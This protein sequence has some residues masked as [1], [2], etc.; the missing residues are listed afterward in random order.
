[1]KERDILFA[2]EHVSEKHISDAAPTGRLARRVIVKWAAV[3]ACLLLCVG[4]VLG[5]MAARDPTP[6]GDGITIPQTQ[7]N[8]KTP[9]DGAY[10]MPGL[11]I[12]GGRVYRHVQNVDN[13]RLCGRYVATVT[14]LIDEWTPK[15]GYVERAGTVPGEIYTVRGYDPDYVLCQTYSSGAVAIYRCLEGVTVYTGRDWFGDIFRLRENLDTVSCETS[16]CRNLGYG[17]PTEMGGEHRTLIRRLMDALYENPVMY[18]ADVPHQGRYSSS[19]NENALYAMKVTLKD[20]LTLT[21]E[22]WRGG[23]VSGGA[24]AVK[25][26]DALW[27]DLL[28]AL[29]TLCGEPWYLESGDIFDCTGEDVL[30]DLMNAPGNLTDAK[31]STSLPPDGRHTPYASM[32]E[33][34]IAVVEALIEAICP[35]T[36]VHE[37]VMCSQNGWEDPQRDGKWYHIHC[38]MTG[39][40]DMPFS[41]TLY[42]GGWVTVGVYPLT[43]YVEDDVFDAIWALCERTVTE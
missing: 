11:F 15:D 42:E 4:T 7:V 30:V 23:Y 24:V 36:P 8:L 38:S 34:G 2:L 25:L 13:P 16:V 5:V 1:M 37:E 33:A 27:R 31:A 3:A 29:G 41:I 40:A 35:L 19:L 39:E 26:E 17:C 10:D 6:I 32:G 18:T 9:T 43:F 14:G 21:L 20:G 22:L 12:Y 28:E